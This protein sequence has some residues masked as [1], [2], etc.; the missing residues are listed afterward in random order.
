[1]RREDGSRVLEVKSY[2]DNDNHIVEVIDDGVGF[3]TSVLD[4]IANR[5]LS[6]DSHERK[7][8]GI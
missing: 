4:I 6:G 5:R 7:P 8:L 1:M 3:D 2:E